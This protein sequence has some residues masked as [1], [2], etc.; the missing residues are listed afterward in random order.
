LPAEEVLD[1]VDRK[2][3]VIG[4]AKLNDCLENGLLHRAVAVLVVRSS[5]RALLQQRSK[6]DLW[7]PGQWTLSCTGHVKRGETYVAA[8]K[9]E[10]AEELGLKSRLKAFRKMLLPRISS[11]GLVEREWVSMFTARSDQQPEIDPV[12]LESVEEVSR[13]SLRQMLAGRQLTPDAKIL[14]RAYL[15]SES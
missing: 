11:K 2:D 8:A 3:R 4:A 7:H 1:I 12:E 15:A 5:G 14:L 6:R 10:L 13:T 9:R